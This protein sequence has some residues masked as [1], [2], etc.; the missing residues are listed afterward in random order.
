MTRTS[1]L[2]CLVL[3]IVA[4]LLGAVAAQQPDGE[5]VLRALSWV[6]LAVGLVAASLLP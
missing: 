1:R 5:V 2:I 6:A 3:A 4:A